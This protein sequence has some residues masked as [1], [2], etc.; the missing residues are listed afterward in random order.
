MSKRQMRQQRF[1]AA[2]ATA[3][4]LLVLPACVSKLS[5]VVTHVGPAGANRVDS[6][7]SGV[8]VLS[9][10]VPKLVGKA[11]DRLRAQCASGEVVN[12][13]SDLRSRNF[14]IVQV[15]TFQL[16]GLCK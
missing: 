7:A 3:I 12:V 6:K 13:N 8:G 1:W 9:L 16:S 5:Q 4:L 2:L 10:T 14:G 15:Y 11:E